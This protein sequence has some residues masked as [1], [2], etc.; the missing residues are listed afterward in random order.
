[1]SRQFWCFIQTTVFIITN[2]N[3]I[4]EHYHFG[5]ANG[6]CGHASTNNKMKSGG[7][8]EFAYFSNWHLSGR[9]TYRIKGMLTMLM[10]R[11]M[12][13]C[14]LSAG[15]FAAVDLPTFLSVRLCVYI[16]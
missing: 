12:H 5:F 16:S 11:S 9:Y 13:A 3:M 15:K 14:R 8:S 10:M 4:I 2:I 7:L 1:M 6:H